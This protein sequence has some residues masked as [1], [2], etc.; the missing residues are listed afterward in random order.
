MYEHRLVFVCAPNVSALLLCKTRADI[1]EHTHKRGDF[2]QLNAIIRRR[3]SVRNSHVH[4][5]DPNCT[6]PRSII[7]GRADAAHQ[8]LGWLFL[9]R[10]QR[11]RFSQRLLV[12]VCSIFS[13]N[14]HTHTECVRAH[15]KTHS[16]CCCAYVCSNTWKCSSL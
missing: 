2:C 5:W 15:M 8:P 7:M 11:I 9:C 6:Y 14:A 13:L 1:F 3:V 10:A 16:A 12:C 4:V